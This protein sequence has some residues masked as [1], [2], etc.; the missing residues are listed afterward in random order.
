MLK[1]YKYGRRRT[2]MLATTLTVAP[3]DPFRLT[4]RHKSDCT[5]QAAAFEFV[6]CATTHS[7]TLPLALAYRLF[8]INSALLIYA[9]SGYG[10]RA[11]RMRHSA[12]VPWRH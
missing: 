12:M 11:S 2:A 9:L 6:D 1:G 7:L 8:F 10:A 4:S 3:I 5:A